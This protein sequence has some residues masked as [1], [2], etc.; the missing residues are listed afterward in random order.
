ME[1]L[2]RTFYLNKLRKLIKHYAVTALIG[3][4]QTGKTTLARVIAEEKK[5]EGES[6]YYF[7]LE[8]PTHL[9]MLDEPQQG[10]EKLTGL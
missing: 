5:K 2:E 1:L 9:K 7:D 3:A 10:L 6:V 8:L 4:R